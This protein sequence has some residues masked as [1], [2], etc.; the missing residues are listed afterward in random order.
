MEA[1][2]AILILWVG[3]VYLFKWPSPM[4]VGTKFLTGVGRK[5][6]KGLWDIAFK[7][8]QERRGTGFAIFHLALWFGIVAT[9]II[10]LGGE[11]VLATVPYWL[12]VITYKIIYDR[13]R[14]QARGK[15]RLWGR[16]RR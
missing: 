14:K 7:N 11:N 8:E 12:M 2:F 16:G 6:M 9:L 5:G 1:I 4:Q 3:G 10:L 15:Q 13:W